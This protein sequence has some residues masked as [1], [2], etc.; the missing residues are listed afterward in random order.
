MT[1]LAPKAIGE[2]L[3]FDIDRVTDTLTV[4]A[5]CKAD[6]A[7]RIARRRLIFELADTDV[8]FGDL[9]EEVQTFTRICCCLKWR[10]R[11]WNLI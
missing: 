3:A 9:A 5:D 6:L 2:V 4:M 1:E 11:S 10:A 8:D 7:S